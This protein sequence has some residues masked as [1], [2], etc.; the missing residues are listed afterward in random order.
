MSSKS[1]FYVISYSCLAIHAFAY[2]ERHCLKA[3]KSCN[4]FMF[5]S[6]SSHMTKQILSWNLIVKTYLTV[7]NCFLLQKTFLIVGNFLKKKIVNLNK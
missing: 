7:E 4:N 5:S 3:L 6:K 2:T 1:D